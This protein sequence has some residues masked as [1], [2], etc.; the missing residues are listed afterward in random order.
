MEPKSCKA[1][2]LLSLWA[3]FALIVVAVIIA[4]FIF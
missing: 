4:P 1:E 3:F 2:W